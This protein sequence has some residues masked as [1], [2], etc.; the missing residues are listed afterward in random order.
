MWFYER[1]T[2]IIRNLYV[3]ILPVAAFL[4]TTFGYV[5]VWYGNFILEATVYDFGLIWTFYLRR[6]LCW[7]FSVVR[8]TYLNFMVMEL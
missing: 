2:G 7:N 6:Y 4:V 1:N 3:S 5:N 8:Q